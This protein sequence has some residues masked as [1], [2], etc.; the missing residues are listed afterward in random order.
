MSVGNNIKKL[1]ELRN[2]TQ[3]YMSIQLE[4]SISAYS[5]I[6]RNETKISLKRL[7]Q[8]SEILNVSVNGII[9]FDEKILL[10][11]TKSNENDIGKRQQI[12]PLIEQMRSEIEFLRQLLNH[13][14]SSNNG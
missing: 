3:T 12:D 13:Q 10:N 14:N 4:I 5:K 7:E 9:Q 2:Y 1:R 11:N 6:E 8:I